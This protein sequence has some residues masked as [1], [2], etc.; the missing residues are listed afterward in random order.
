MV[1]YNTT[2]AVEMLKRLYPNGMDEL[3]YK[4]VPTLG[5]MKRW[6]G[7]KAEGKYLVF[8]FGSNGGGSTDFTV[9][10]A[11]CTADAFARPFITRTKEYA[12]ATIDNEFLQA[13]KGEEFAVAEALKNATDS[14]IYNITRSVGFHLFRDG[15]GERGRLA[16]SSSG[17][18][19]ATIQLDSTSSMQGFEKNLYVQAGTKSGTVI[20]LASG[21]A[22]IFKVNRTLKT[23]TIESGVWNDV[24]HI[25]NIADGYVLVREGDAQ[26]V[27][28]T[29]KVING[30]E[31]WMPAAGPSATAFY[32]IDRTQDPTRLAGIPFTGDGN[33]EETLIDAAAQLRDNGGEPD[34]VIMNCA[35]S[36]DLLKS[37]GSKA[38]IPAKSV[39]KPN[40]S[41]DGVEL[42]TPAGRLKVVEDPCCPV[43]KA[44]M[45]T[46]DTW[47]VWQ[48]GE[49]PHVLDSDGNQ[50]LRQANADGIEL[51]LGGYLALTCNNPGANS[52]I[53][54]V[55]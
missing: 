12:L 46:S 42:F 39:A 27:A 9:A 1:S 26:T 2:T 49:V 8:K 43:G 6:K 24:S 4:K 29:N 51:R 13:S 45:L 37:V 14:A 53:T 7:F 52:P 5:M 15:S 54:L 33:H 38:N 22:Q 25:P 55:G 18:A 30:F 19:T 47:E 28:G 50:V 3:L 32:G 16:S 36:G 17:V 35:D 21:R 41:Y 23:L 11:N 31:A 48:M 20:T 40:I 10:Q 34:L 44:Y